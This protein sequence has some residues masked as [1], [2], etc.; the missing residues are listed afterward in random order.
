M[1][2][3]TGLRPTNY[4]V[5]NYYIC[6]KHRDELGVHWRRPQRKCQSPTHP[7]QSASHKE[8]GAKLQFQTSMGVTKKHLS[9]G[10]RVIKDVT[11]CLVRM[12]REHIKMPTHQEL[13]NVMGGFHEISGF[14]NEIGTIDGKH[15][16]IKTPPTCNDEHL[17]VNRKKYYS[18][19]VQGP[20]CV[21]RN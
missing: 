11:N 7:D 18:I 4:Y 15:I 14:P 20:G 5:L 8:R 13:L 2:M 21:I 19:N 1:N 6:G 3:A 10:S 17:F 16:R 12:S 9:Y